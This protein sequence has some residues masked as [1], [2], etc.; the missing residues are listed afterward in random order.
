M[1]IKTVADPIPVYF[2]LQTKL[3]Q[4]IESGHLEPGVSIPPERQLAET[5]KVSIGTV[6]KA[7]LNLVNEGFLYRLQGK[8][9]FVAGTNLRR[10]NLRYYRY[11][12]DFKSQEA[13][14]KINFLEINKIK[15]IDPINRFLE[16]RLNQDLYELRRLF[17]AGEKPTIFTVSYLPQKLFPNLEDFPRSRF[18][19]ITIFNSLEQSYGL[20]TIFNRE[21]FSTTIA[22][23]G[24]AKLLK[25]KKGTPILYIEMKAFTY[26]EKPYEYRKS[27][28]LTE[29]K[30]IFREW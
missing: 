13:S 25:I 24:V 6:K 29:T 7:I 27:F 1:I 3:R 16:I 22:D 9:T 12:A 11:L 8:G 15:G 5:Y 30:K 17:T 4:E 2:K 21:L 14:I 20:P 19:R 10:E 18:E 23:D 26:K 28:C